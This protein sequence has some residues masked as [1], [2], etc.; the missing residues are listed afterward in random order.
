MVKNDN[1]TKRHEIIKS[2]DGVLYSHKEYMGIKIPEKDLDTESEIQLGHTS[3][4]IASK[5]LLDLKRAILIMNMR[6]L[7]LRK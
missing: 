4:S 1:T 6:L 7:S 2:K 3:D 5:V